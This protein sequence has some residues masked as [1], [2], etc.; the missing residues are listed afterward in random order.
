MTKAIIFGKCEINRKVFLWEHQFKTNIVY[1]RGER[2]KT[3]EW[4]E[5]NKLD[6]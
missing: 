2:I 6:V 5:N 4:D 3:C 1:F